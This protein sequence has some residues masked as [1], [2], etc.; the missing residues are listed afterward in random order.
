MWGALIFSHPTPAGEARSRIPS[1]R[2]PVRWGAEAQGARG[3]RGVSPCTRRP[4][5]VLANHPSQPGRADPTPR[6]RGPASPA[7]VSG[8]QPRGRALEGRTGVRCLF[9]S[10]TSVA[11]HLGV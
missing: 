4:A 10:S 7:G 8:A 3:V 2:D 9:P 5:S 11:L 6:T 1:G